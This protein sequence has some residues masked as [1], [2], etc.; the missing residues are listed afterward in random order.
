MSFSDP[1][2]YSALASGYPLGPVPDADAGIAYENGHAGNFLNVIS[3]A[4]DSLGSFDGSER[5]TAGYVMNTTDVGALQV[6]VGVR[7]EATHSTYVGHSLSTPTDSAGNPTGPDVLAA[8]SRT[9]DYTHLFP[10]R[11]LPSPVDAAT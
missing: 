3:A 8:G 2:F 7:V 6:N 11:R 9:K 4:S 1:G 10:R 5:I